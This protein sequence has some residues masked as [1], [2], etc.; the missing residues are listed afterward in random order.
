MDP[1]LGYL[2]YR[3]VE[4]AGPASFFPSMTTAFMLFLIWLAFS[5]TVKFIP[6]FYR[7]P[8]DLKFLPILYAFCYFHSFIYLYTLFTL[9]KVSSPKSLLKD[10]AWLILVTDNLGWWSCR[11][12]VCIRE[13]WGRGSAFFWIRSME[14]KLCCGANW[15]QAC[16]KLRE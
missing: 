8:S 1:L 11:Y 3:A 13:E 9:H 14:R 7:Y 12:R 10:L 4:T 5:K 6:Y 16:R 15:T 2:L